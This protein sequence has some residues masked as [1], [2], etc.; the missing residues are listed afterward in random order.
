MEGSFPVPKATETYADSVGKRESANE[1]CL[2]MAAVWSEIRVI[3]AT[4]AAG[5]IL[6]PFGDTTLGEGNPLGVTK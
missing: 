1:F 2:P 4:E 6:R 3:Q 5:A